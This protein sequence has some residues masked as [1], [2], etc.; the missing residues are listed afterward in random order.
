M[1]DIPV[2]SGSDN[3]HDI[4]AVFLNRPMIFDPAM[5]PQPF[6]APTVGKK[7]DINKPRPSL[8]PV[9]SIMKILEVLEFGAKKYGENNWQHVMPHTRYFDAALRHL[10]AW[11]SGEKFDSESGLSHFAHAA[12]CLL[13][14]LH[15]ELN[16]KI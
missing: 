6:D 3:T 4:N 9:D 7:F 5:Y 10:F 16:G 8:L 13:F 12:T 15:F 11:Q 14:L 1:I 2:P